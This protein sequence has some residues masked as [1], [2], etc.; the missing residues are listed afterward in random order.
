MAA[1]RVERKDFH[2]W[3]LLLVPL[4]ARRGQHRVRRDLKIYRSQTRQLFQSHAPPS[5]F[6]TSRTHLLGF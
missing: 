4:Q 1:V 3:L 2:R 6:Y 5:S